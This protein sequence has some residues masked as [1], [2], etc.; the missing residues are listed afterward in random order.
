[1]PL[2][3]LTI[4]AVLTLIAVAGVACSGSSRGE[5]GDFEIGTYQTAGVLNGTNTSLQEVLDRG[6]P[7]VLNFWGG[8]CPPCRAE[9]P[10]LEDAWQEH[11]DDIVML[12]VDVG[13]MF[14]LGTIA[15][16]QQLLRDT[17][18]TY[19]N[20]NSQ[21]GSIFEDFNMAGLPATFFVLP[22]GE[23]TDSWPAAISSGQ[24]RRRIVDL[25]E[26]HNAG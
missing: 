24:L 3:R 23:I 12:G 9:M 22:S 18:V 19:P 10:V 20:G 7:V 15:Q 17:G 26:T 11:K 16:G 8:N 25:V 14:G 2:S 4:V 13:P 5:G 21:S 1:M 6:Q